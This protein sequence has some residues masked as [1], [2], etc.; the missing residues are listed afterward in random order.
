ME[1]ELLIILIVLF[2]NLRLLIFPY[3]TLNIHPQRKR[4]EVTILQKKTTNE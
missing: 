3:L 2:G 4:T 1:V